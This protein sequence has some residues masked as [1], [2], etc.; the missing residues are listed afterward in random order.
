[1]RTHT[2]DVCGF[3]KLIHKFVGVCVFCV[4]VGYTQRLQLWVYV[5]VCVHVGYTDTHTHTHTHIPGR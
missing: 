2:A 1:M 4:Y 3:G 5:N